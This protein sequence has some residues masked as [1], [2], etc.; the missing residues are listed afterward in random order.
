M[1]PD[2]AVTQ[3]GNGPAESAGPSPNAAESRGVEPAEHAAIDSTPGIDARSLDDAPIPAPVIPFHE[4]A[5]IFPVGDDA[6]IRDLAR[7]IVGKVPIDPVILYE[8]KILDGAALHLA[9]LM[10]GREPT[11]ET[12]TGDDPVGYLIDRH[13]FRGPLSESQ[14]AM[15]AARAATGG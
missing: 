7:R 15:A 6:S 13:L 8:D 5:G 4:L 11:S 3:I 14:P 12:Y 2:A 1:R 9:C 10:V